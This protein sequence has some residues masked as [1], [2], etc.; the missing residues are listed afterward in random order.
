MLKLETAGAKLLAATN[1]HSASPLLVTREHV[2]RVTRD[3]VSPPESC[4]AALGAAASVRRDSTSET[5]QCAAGGGAVHSA[6]CGHRGAMET[7]E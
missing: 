6:D 7:A 2:S 1:Q 5:A 3:T 4:S